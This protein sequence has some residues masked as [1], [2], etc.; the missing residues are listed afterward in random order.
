MGW[1]FGMAEREREKTHATSLYREVVMAEFSWIYQENIS[2]G[3]SAETMSFAL[4]LLLSFGIRVLAYA[5]NAARTMHK[6]PFEIFLQNLA[7]MFC[8]RFGCAFFS[9]PFVNLNKYSRITCT[10]LHSAFFY[11]TVCLRTHT[12]YMYISV[13]E[14]ICDDDGNETDMLARIPVIWLH[15]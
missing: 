11:L 7:V 12:T 6:D 14:A 5:L 4:L 8:I 13:M 3:I 9:L 2:W 15:E 1:T 10:W